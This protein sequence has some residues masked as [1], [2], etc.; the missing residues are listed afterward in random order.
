[1]GQL[2]KDTVKLD[3]SQRASPD[4]DSNYSGDSPSAATI[5]NYSED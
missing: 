3:P 5:K 1:M 2:L 4:L